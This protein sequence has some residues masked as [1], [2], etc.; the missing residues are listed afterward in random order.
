MGDGVEEPPAARGAV[1]A[2]LAEEFPGLYLRW[3]RVER[4]SG[5]SPRAL[6]HRLALLSDRFAGPQ[7]IAFRTKPIPHAYRVFHRHIGLDPDEQPPGP[8]LAVR[9]R[10]LKGG[11]VS[12]NLLDDALTIAMIESGVPVLAFDADAVAGA[13]VIRPTVPGEGLEG[14]PGELPAGTLVI[15]DELRPI[16]LLFGATASGRGVS[17]RTMCTL[18]VVVGVAGV[19]EI[20]T[21]EALW[22]VAEILE[23]PA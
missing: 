5:R 15:A 17:P 11:F 7:A 3:R 12:S 1:D 21:E 22:I 9:E 8:E 16:A 20:A 6:K 4:G 13:P 18:L 23:A 2:A 10:M 14:R 19:P